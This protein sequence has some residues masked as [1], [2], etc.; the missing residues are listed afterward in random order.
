MTG[1]VETAPLTGVRQDERNTHLTVRFML[2]LGRNAARRGLGNVVEIMVIGRLHQ[3][4]VTVRLGCWFQFHV[5]QLCVGVKRVR[6]LSVLIL[7]DTYTREVRRRTPCP[8]T[9]WYC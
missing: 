7:R 6:P 2:P 5:P 3:R 4:I 9:L 8:E 1:I